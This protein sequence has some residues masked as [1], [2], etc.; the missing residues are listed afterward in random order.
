MTAGALAD[1]RDVV[2]GIHPPVLAD[3][4]LSA[5]VE[6]LALDLAVP[7]TVVSAL[8]GCPPAALESALYFA[9][10]EALANVVRHASASRVR[11]QLTADGA[12]LRAAVEDD[13]VGGADPAA[14]SGL[15]GVARRL[16]AFDGTMGVDSPPG[17]PT[18]IL[19]EVPCVWSS[20]RTT[21]S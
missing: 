9:V 3:R 13:G 20:P 6:A 17:G 12:T 21:P 10:A 15:R 7:V 4:G 11:V 18:R 2:Q 8:P 5:A 1:L 14:G 19:L 16:T